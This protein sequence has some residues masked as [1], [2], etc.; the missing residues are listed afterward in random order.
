[1]YDKEAEN[2]AKKRKLFCTIVDRGFGHWATGIIPLTVNSIEEHQVSKAMYDT[3]R[4]Y[5]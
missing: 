1:M 2:D 3:F 5:P 4:R